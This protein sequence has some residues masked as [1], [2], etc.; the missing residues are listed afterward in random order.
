MDSVTRPEA[1]GKWQ[2][3]IVWLSEICDK[4]VIW[5]GA[6]LLALMTIDILVA[7]FFRYVLADTLVWSEEAARYMMIWM[8]SLAMSTG[9]KRGEHLTINILVNALP[10]KAA[11]WL[12]MVIRFILFLFLLVL[13]VYG[14]GLVIANLDFTSQA[15][16]LNMSIPTSAIPLAGALMIIQLIITTILKFSD[17]QP[18]IEGGSQ[19]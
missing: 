9:I 17:R 1:P 10:P 13:T 4:A 11:F 2:T 18:E 5:V 12:D 8:A 15:T 6:I 7:V 19:C 3:K 14:V 16:E